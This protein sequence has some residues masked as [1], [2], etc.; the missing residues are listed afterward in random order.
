MCLDCAGRWFGIRIRRRKRTKRWCRRIDKHPM[1]SGILPSTSTTGLPL[2]STTVHLPDFTRYHL[3]HQLRILRSRPVQFDVHPDGLRLCRKVC[4][5]FPMQPLHLHRQFERRH[6][7]IEA[8]HRFRRWLGIHHSRS[9]AIY[10]RL[11]SEKSFQQ[12]PVEPVHRIG[13]QHR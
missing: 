2:R 10:L 1:W 4:R 3:Q 11:H 7:W 9:V 5:W 12:P 8:S 6:L 13:S